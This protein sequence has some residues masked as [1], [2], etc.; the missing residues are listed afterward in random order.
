MTGVA[1][2]LVAAAIWSRW[3]WLVLALVVVTHGQP[4]LMALVVMAA[5]WALWRGG[6]FRPTDADFGGLLGSARL[7]M[8]ADL[9]TAGQVG[10]SGLFLGTMPLT[11]KEARALLWSAPRWLDREVLTWLF[12]PWR[13]R[14]CP[15]K[16]GQGEGPGS[17]A[18]MRATTGS[19]ME[20]NQSGVH[21]ICLFR[22]CRR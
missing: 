20:S 14:V 1:R 19:G 18:T 11:G 4:G 16:A 21:E 15:C 6:R 12:T 5:V 22:S 17:L 3:P 9:V 7:A 10:P 8:A 13:Q 2:W